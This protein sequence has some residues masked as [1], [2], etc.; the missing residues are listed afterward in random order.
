MKARKSG[1]TLIE[2]LV[3]MTILAMAFSVLFALS[4]RSLD[5]MRRARDIERR[6]G[7]A[8]VK[9]DE[10]RLIDDL[11]AGDQASGGLDDGT[12]W[13]VEVMPFVQPVREGPGLTP[14]SVVRIQLSLEWQGRNEPQRWVIDSYRFVRYSTAVHVP[15]EEKLRE[16]ARR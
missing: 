2:V 6:V 15:L 12:R 1:F 16:I 7:F 13:R 3:A 5:G 10:L 4:S 8:R 9:L 14:D 11:R